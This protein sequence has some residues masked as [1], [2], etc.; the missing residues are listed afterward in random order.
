MKCYLGKAYNFLHP[1]RESSKSINRDRM[2]SV[3]KMATIYWVLSMCQ[4]LHISLLFILTVTLRGGHFSSVCF[5][6]EETL[7]EKSS[8]WGSREGQR[9][10]WEDSAHLPPSPSS[11]W[12]TAHAAL[13]LRDL[14]GQDNLKDSAGHRDAETTALEGPTAFFLAEQICDRPG[15][16][17]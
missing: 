13:H 16:E 9:G 7:T 6:E 3:N 5:L 10:R 4:V 2:D 14:S 17:C 8:S 12:A 11:S 1:R 15:C